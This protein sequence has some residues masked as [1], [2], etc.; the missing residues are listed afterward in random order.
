[1]YEIGAAAFA[2]QH[3]HAALAVGLPLGGWATDHFSCRWMFSSVFR[4]DKIFRGDNLP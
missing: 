4:I 1:M 2:L 3:D